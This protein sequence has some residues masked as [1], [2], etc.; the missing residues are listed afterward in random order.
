MCCSP[1]EASTVFAAHRVT[2]AQLSQQGSQLAADPALMCRLGSA[3]Y[4]WQDVAPAVMGALAFGWDWQHM[5]P[6][7]GGIPVKVPASEARQ[8]Q[9]D[10]RKVSMDTQ[11]VISN[12]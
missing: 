10:A 4:P 11:C 7:G 9:L 3:L 1:E 2:E 8:L 5:L 6:A 12:S